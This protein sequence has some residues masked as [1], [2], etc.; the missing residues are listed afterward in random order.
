MPPQQSYDEIYGSLASQ[1]QPQTDLINT[2]LAQLPT[3]Q[4]AQQASLDQAKVNAFKD[5]TNQ[6]NSR[7]VLFSGVPIDQ[8]STYVGTKYLPAVANMNTSFNNQKTSLLGSLNNVNA[9]R[10]TTARGIQSNQQ[11]QLAAYQKAQEDAAYKQ[12]Q[13]GLSYARLGQSGA[14]ASNAAATKAAAQYKTQQDQNGNY[15]FVGPGNQPV[16]LAG[17]LQGRYGGL[18]ANQAL[19]L[20][21]NGSSYDKKIYQMATIQLGNKRNDPNAVFNMLAK[22]DTG[23]YYGLR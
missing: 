5:I 14:N 12:A 19:D 2:Q 20:I 6:S 10:M 23:N 11:Q 8:Q 15:R 22:L 18:D 21:S 1:Y 4:A 16:K 17:Y 13:L 7:G 3:Q 9:Q